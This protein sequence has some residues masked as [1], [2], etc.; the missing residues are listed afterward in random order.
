MD[1]VSPYPKILLNTMYGKGRPMMTTQ[2]ETMT[3]DVRKL[4]TEKGWRDSV[5]GTTFAEYIAL[6]HSELS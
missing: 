5:L 1:Y 4:N 6:T 2:L 3:N